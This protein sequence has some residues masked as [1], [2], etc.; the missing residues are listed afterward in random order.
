MEHKSR[1]VPTSFLNAGVKAV[2]FPDGKLFWLA[3]GQTSF[4]RKVGARQIEGLF[5]VLAHEK[6][7]DYAGNGVRAKVEIDWGSSAADFAV[8]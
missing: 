6:Y 4:H 2:L 8:W 3:F 1:R 7:G 5:V